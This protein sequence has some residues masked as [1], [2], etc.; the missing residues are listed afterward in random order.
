MPRPKPWISSI[1]FILKAVKESD[2][3]EYTRPEVEKLFNIGRTAALE[4]MNVVG[5]KL[6][7]DS[8]D[9]GLVVSKSK[10]VAYL[11]YGP[12]AAAG[13]RELARRAKVAKTLESAAEG[14]RLRSIE[15]RGVARDAADYLLKDLAN[16]SISPGLLMV[17]F[18]DAVDLLSQLYK[19]VQAVG[20]PDEPGPYGKKWETFVQMCEKEKA[21]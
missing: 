11:S 18:S 12:E 10:L 6:A 9:G 21:S 15:L 16:V 7:G 3:R 14:Q 5:S 1:P 2:Q 13:A 20:L 17:V 8:P 4:L 19:L